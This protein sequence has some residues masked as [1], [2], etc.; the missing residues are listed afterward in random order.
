MHGNC[1]R[2]A[3]LSLPVQESRRRAGSLKSC[4]NLQWD[5]VANDFAPLWLQRDLRTA[6]VAFGRDLVDHFEAHLS[7][8]QAM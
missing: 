1:D 4:T 6:L 2:A 8:W 7:V 3:A 5:V